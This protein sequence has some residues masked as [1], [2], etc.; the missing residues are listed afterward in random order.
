MPTHNQMVDAGEE[1]L[2]PHVWPPHGPATAAGLNLHRPMVVHKLPCA[3]VVEGAVSSERSAL[4]V[5]IVLLASRGLAGPSYCTLCRQLSVLRARVSGRFRAR[6]RVRAGVAARGAIGNRRGHQ[7]RIGGRVMGGVSALDRGN[8]CPGGGARWGQNRVRGGLC[9]I[10]KISCVHFAADNETQ[11][12]QFVRQ[13]AA[14]SPV[15]LWK[16]HFGDTIL[17][18]EPISVVPGAVT[19]LALDEGQQVADP[20]A[21]DAEPISAGASDKTQ[22]L[23]KVGPV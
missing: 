21:L 16:P 15:A 12:A 19:V 8:V 17:K 6:A 11:P 7:V 1:Q 22:Q 20:L 9:Q 5:P 13:N 23:A 4:C 18:A 2:P 3:D 14:V 10:F